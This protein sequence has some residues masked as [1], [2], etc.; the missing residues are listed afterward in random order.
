MQLPG[1]WV[2]DAEGNIEISFKKFDDTE[3]SDVSGWTEA[4]QNEEAD[5]AHGFLDPLAMLQHVS[6]R[7]VG[8]LSERELNEAR[9]IF[10][11][12]V[13]SCVND[14]GSLARLIQVLIP[15][16]TKA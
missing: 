7:L 8:R 12:G 4:W 14:V 10:R 3:L 16:Q 13:P 15:R 1:Y 2:S 6:Q 5:N 11:D 9:S